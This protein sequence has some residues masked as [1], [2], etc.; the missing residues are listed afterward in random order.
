MDYHHHGTVVANLDRLRAALA[1]RFLFRRLGGFYCLYA[2]QVL[3]RN[4]SDQ[5]KQAHHEEEDNTVI[6]RTVVTEDSSANGQ[7]G[8][9]AKTQYE[10]FSK[11]I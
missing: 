7:A 9:C 10:P 4:R 6:R 11:Y 3:L 5:L 1:R 2:P 8:A